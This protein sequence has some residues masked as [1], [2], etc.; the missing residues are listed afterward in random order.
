MVVFSIVSPL[1]G[2]CFLSYR[3]SDPVQPG[4]LIQVFRFP[5]QDR[6]DIRDHSCG[7]RALLEH[8]LLRASDLAALYGFEFFKQTALGEQVL[9]PLQI[10]GD[11]AVVDQ[12]IGVPRLCIE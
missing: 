10:P 5:A 2:V 4:Q 6:V 12:H 9:H 8:A 3:L 7:G 1:S 11:G